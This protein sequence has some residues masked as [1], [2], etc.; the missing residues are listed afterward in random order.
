MPAFYLPFL[1]K[2]QRKGALFR[3]LQRKIVP[4]FRNLLLKNTASLF[5]RVWHEVNER[6]C[7]KT[8]RRKSGLLE[9]SLPL[10]TLQLAHTVKSEKLPLLGWASPYV[11]PHR[12]TTTP[13]GASAFQGEPPHTSPCRSTTSPSG[14]DCLCKHDFGMLQVKLKGQKVSAEQQSFS[15]V[16]AK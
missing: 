10:D 8:D 2:K 14:C 3:T 6:H 5:L 9:I 13:P 16:F 11:P 1:T 15:L 7:G 12:S 4:L